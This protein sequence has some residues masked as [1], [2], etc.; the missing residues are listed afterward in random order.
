MKMSD[1]R[2]L[3]LED[4]SLLESF[5]NARDD[6]FDG[7]LEN[8]L[9][10]QYD[11]YM[12]NR[13]LNAMGG[14]IGFQD[15]GTE[16]EAELLKFYLDEGLDLEDAQD[17]VKSV[18]AGEAL[19]NGGRVGLQEGG[20]PQDE[21]QAAIERLREAQGAL[22]KDSI[23]VQQKSPGIEAL[24]EVYGPELANLLKTP[25]RPG[26][27]P[28]VYGSFL[29]EIAAQ[30][31]AQTQA[32]NLA[33]QQATGGPGG[34]AAFQPFLNQATQAAN[35][36]Q[37]AATTGQGAGQQ[38]IQN[39]LNQANLA[40]LAAIQGQGAGQAGI[41]QAQAI[42]NQMQQA[43]VAGQQAAQPF[44]QAA[45]QFTGP[46]A[47]EQF[48]SPYQQQVIDTTREELQRELDRQQTQLGA[49]AVQSGAFGGGRFGVA[50]GELAAQGAQGI[51]QTIA[52]L[53]Q[54]GFQQAQQAAA[55]A[56]AQQLGLGSAAQ[57]QAAANLGLFGQGLQGQLAG[58]Q[59]AQQ[60]AAQ[61]LA[62]F[63]AAGQQQLG[64][65]S[66]LMQ[67][68]GQNVGLAGQALAGQAGLAQLQPQLAAQNVG[69]LGQFGQQQQL[70]A[71]AIIDAEKQGAK[72]IAYEPYDRFG[73][74]GG[75][76]TGIMGGYPGGVS[77]SSQ[78]QQTPNPF[79]QILGGLG[80]IAGI[81]IGAKQAG[82]FG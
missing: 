42:A 38:A 19:A 66:G 50:Q 58:T 51:A 43:A 22:P 56:L 59:A 76:L 4:P 24:L 75:Q 79:Q 60:Q 69:L 55:Q 20:T 81:G 64:A 14:R 35:L 36:Q 10:F 78:M 80:T 82:F 67:Q 5:R 34:V 29:P 26:G 54:Q 46:Q 27:L 1:I 9:E 52:G 23:S 8:F 11:K 2:K 53:Q 17:M 41:T 48:M 7:D 30:D 37:Q 32:Y 61:N 49:A 70:Q 72:M 65:G 39:A 3:I 6:G 63:G 45:Q 77:F 31:A 25:I 44:L 40:G 16:R 13:E 71:Q 15:G 28:G 57:Q 68:A 47:F 73:F 12:E 74:F 21:Y 62:L 33:V 18:L